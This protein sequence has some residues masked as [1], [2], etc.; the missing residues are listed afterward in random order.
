MVTG[1]QSNIELYRMKNMLYRGK[2]SQGQAN[3]SFIGQYM[4]YIV[5]EYSFITYSDPDAC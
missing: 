1:E 4:Y 3:I 5:G 2:A